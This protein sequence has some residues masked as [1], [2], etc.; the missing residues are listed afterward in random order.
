MNQEIKDKKESLNLGFSLTAFLICAVL[1][2]LT[3]YLLGRLWWCKLGDYSI[4][5]NEAWNSSHTSQHFLDPYTFTHILHGVMFFWLASLIFSR[6]SVA[7]QFTIAIFAEAAWEVLE[8]SNFIIEKYRENTA[9][10]DY[11]GDSIFNSV[12][13]LVACAVGFWVTLKLGWWKSLIFFLLVEII[14]LWWIRD[15]LLL[16]I[17]MLIYPLDSVKNWQMNIS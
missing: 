7:W 4:Y 16:N 13:D 10:L 17:L 11:F 1:M 6:L 12:G 15:G 5:I 14:L 2:I 3:L 8:N 9:S